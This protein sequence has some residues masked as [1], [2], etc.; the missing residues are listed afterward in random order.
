MT[1]IGAQMIEENNLEK[2]SNN[3][4]S[5]KRRRGRPRKRILD[6]E[7]NYIIEGCIDR[8]DCKRTQIEHK[9]RFRAMCI[10]GDD[11][12]FKWLVDLE[13]LASGRAKSKSTILAALGRIDDPLEMKALAYLICQNKLKTRD[14][15][16]VIRH[17]RIGESPV[18]VKQL[19]K[20]IINTVVDY[21]I[22]HPSL[23]DEDIWE[24]FTIA[25]ACL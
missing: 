25:N 19:A 17:H 24:A 12:E 6:P 18:N 1:S 5:P 23:T 7:Q 8:A 9:Y 4:D 16:S 14:A 10:L 3:P 11:E 2:F 21:K 13:A 20:E 15:I 22:R